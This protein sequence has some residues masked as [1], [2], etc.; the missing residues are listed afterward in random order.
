MIALTVGLYFKQ[1]SVV[2]EY[3][4]TTT[5]GAI[6]DTQST[7]KIAQIVGNA[8]TGAYSSADNN[9]LFA[10]IAN[11]DAN[12]RTIVSIDTYY[13]GLNVKTS[14]TSPTAS[15]FLVRAATS[16]DATTLNSNT[17]LFYQSLVATSS[18]IYFE[19]SSTPGM[20][21]ANINR[22]WPA[23][24]NINFLSRA[25]TSATVIFRISYIAQ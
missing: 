3:T 21:T 12:D 9:Y 10:S 17:N 7:S 20:A 16:T 24:T 2:N 18:S 8:A 13:S 11:N 22:I 4:T 25:T 1:S 14:T 23:G 15:T 6:G 19:A 5:A